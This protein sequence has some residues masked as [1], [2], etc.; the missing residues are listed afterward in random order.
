MRPGRW[1][2]PALALLAG[3]LPA[4]A[5]MRVAA[6]APPPDEERVNLDYL[7]YFGGLNV[8]KVGIELGLTPERYDLAARSQ[9]VGI[10]GFLAPWIS[11]ATSRGGIDGDRVEPLQHRVDAEFRGQPR[12]IAIDFIDGEVSHVALHPPASTHPRDEIPPALRRGALDP[13]SALFAL[14]RVMGEGKGCAGRVPVFDGRRRYDVVVVEKGAETLAPNDYSAF[15]GE[16]IR[17]DFH[18]EPL[19]VA[20][21]ENKRRFRSGR[22]WFAAV[23]PGRP[24]VPVRLEVDG[25]YVQTLVHLSEMPRSSNG[26]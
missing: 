5:E 6:L 16:A 15:Q 13:A 24:V 12:T 19:V 10:T 1:T 9:T 23:L 3:I 26:N 2:I 7:V 25:D 8:L 22:A 14:V 4:G 17:C 20:A 21:P 18:V 11:L